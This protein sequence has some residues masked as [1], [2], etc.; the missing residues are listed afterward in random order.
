M[1]RI[2]SSLILFL[3]LFGIARNL[4]A[5]PKT[6]AKPVSQRWMDMDRAQAD[7]ILLRAQM[8]PA[9]TRLEQLS[10]FFLKTPYQLNPLGEGK[11][12]NPDS[13]PVFRLD[14]VDCV[15]LLEQLWGMVRAKT[16]PD[17][18]LQTQKIRY[19]EGCRGYSC[20]L[21]FMWSQWI[22][23]NEKRG[24]IT[25]I[26][27]QIAGKE[28]RS[29]SKNVLSPQ[30]YGEKW[31][32]YCESLGDYFSAGIVEHDL[33]PIEWASV[34]AAKLP[35]GT[36]LMVVL[37]DRS[38][39]PYRIKHSGVIVRDEKGRLRFRHASTYHHKVVDVSLQAYLTMVKEKGEKWP[40]SGVILLKPNLD[41]GV[42]PSSVKQPEKAPT[43]T[44]SN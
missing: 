35:P 9:E 39:L 41:A 42:K 6:A 24:Y 11:T 1:A 21:H 10:R 22:V 27:R 8:L 14:A 32:T 7:S 2:V 31:R 18:A 15:T 33:I 13:D 43:S 19:F 36:F 30:R 37:Q 20:R 16:L 40:A 5:A 3:L 17:A 4:Q 12:A 44:Q 25:N 29:E 34:H 23:E 28:A 26:S 38:W